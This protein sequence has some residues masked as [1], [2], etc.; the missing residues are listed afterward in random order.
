MLDWQDYFLTA[1]CEVML[2]I[3]DVHEAIP[4]HRDGEHGWDDVKPQ[5]VC[6]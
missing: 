4:T 5:G 3:M 1:F 6:G 2:S